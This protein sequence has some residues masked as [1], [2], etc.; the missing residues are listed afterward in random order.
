MKKLAGVLLASLLY[1]GQAHP[2]DE[3]VQGAY[4]TLAPGVV[5][6]ELDLTLGNQVAGA[7]LD[8]LDVNAD[9][10][11]TDAEARAYAQQVLEQSTLMLS[12]VT[13]PWTLD[14]VTMPP[15]QNLNVGSDTLKVY[16]VAERPDELGEQSLSY[17]NR[18]QPVK[19]QWTAN[20]FLQPAADWQYQVADQGRSDDG[21]QLT[22]TY[23]VTRP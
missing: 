16:A 9:Q 20:V 11:I 18:Y 14:R 6:L 13:V 5:K 21:Q 7:V 17:Q 3:V 12:G 2:V 19:S 23:Q 15:Y 4:L 8:T 22:V 1:V 10:T